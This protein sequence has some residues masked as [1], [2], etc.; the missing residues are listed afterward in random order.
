MLELRVGNH[1]SQS[2]QIPVRWFIGIEILEQLKEKKIDN[3]H[4]LLSV[5]QKQKEVGRYVAPLTDCMTHITF[6]RPGE[7]RICAAIV[8]SRKETV[9]VIRNMIL[10]YSLGCAKV[11]E[12]GK[13][14]PSYFDDIHT[15]VLREKEWE[16]EV[17][18][19]VLVRYDFDD[20][21][22]Y[23]EKLVSESRHSYW[24]ATTDPIE[25]AEG[26]F[27]KPP[28]EWM[29]WWANLFFSGPAPKDQC[30]FRRRKM[31]AFTIQLPL[32]VGYLLGRTLLGSLIV[33]FMALWA[34]RGIKIAPIFHPWTYEFKEIWSTAGKSVFTHDHEGKERDSAIAVLVPTNI[35]FGFVIAL[36]SMFLLNSHDGSPEPNLGRGYRETVGQ[37]GYIALSSLF[38]GPALSFLIL[39]GRLILLLVL[40]VGSVL[41]VLVLKPIV[42]ILSRLGFV[43][44]WLYAPIALISAIG[45]WK[46]NRR[47]AHL[48]AEKKRLENLSK[49][50][51]RE[52]ESL[53]LTDSEPPPV[54]YPSLPSEKKTWKLWFQHVKGKVCRPFARG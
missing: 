25:V 43:G 42:F 33:L 37:L 6:D 53:F 23:E 16:E 38:S 12:N 39:T 20:H 48:E 49:E 10:G 4:I 46:K 50:L 31:F 36:I 44:R 40:F 9:K 2:A 1:L 14:N 17:L 26:F 19:N 34:K 54:G 27:A 8:Y 45:N 24:T 35:L 52:F 51:D 30:S 29:K 21:P 7:H 41:N 47:L 28:S 5:F 15:Q 32:V 13:F 22:I 11:D 18:E 3:A